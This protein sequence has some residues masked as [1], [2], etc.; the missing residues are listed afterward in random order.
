MQKNN[1][2][3]SAFAEWRRNWTLVLASA[4][5][6]S[7]ATIHLYSAG[8]FIEP[9]E[10]QFGWSRAQIVSGITLASVIGTFGSPCTGY[11]IDSYGPRRIALPGMLIFCGGIAMLSLVGGEIWQWWLLWLIVA[12]GWVCIKPTVWTAAISSR[13]DKSRGLALAVALSGTGIGAVLAPLTAGMLIG[14][15]GWRLAY[16]MLVGLWVLI[17]FPLVWL[18]FRGAQDAQVRGQPQGKARQVGLPGLGVREA[19]YSARFVKILCAAVLV[20]VSA[21]GLMMHMVPI[22]SDGGLDRTAAVRVAGI[23][24]LATVT[25]R[26]AM[27]VLLD[28]VHGP[29]IC[30]AIFLFP[31][32]AGLFL[33]RYDGSFLS[34]MVIA[35][36][37]GLALGAELDGLAYF[38]SRYFGLRNFGTLFGT[39]V[40]LISLGTG[41]GPL[42]AGAIYDSFGTYRPFLWLVIPSSALA[43]I[44]IGTLGR[45]P[46]FDGEGAVADA[47]PEDRSVQGRALP[48][49][50]ST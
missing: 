28:R 32:V 30:A 45:Y 10:R 31:M 49:V 3:T 36:C 5:G 43:A 39:I 38:A 18:F 50:R 11:L 8:I 1:S 17:A 41:V 12:L 4:F 19:I 48:Q 27:G 26:L 7:V 21:T 42:I 13:F 23:M 33:L 6:I 15:F 44:L 9:L 20:T 34:A 29:L 22:L 25:G 40:G 2:Q 35:C 14:N 24:G 47:E 46:V 37:V 16:V